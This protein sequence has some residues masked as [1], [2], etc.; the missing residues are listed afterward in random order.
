MQNRLLL[1]ALSFLPLVSQAAHLHVLSSND[2]QITFELNIDDW[3]VRPLSHDRDSLAVFAFDGA[4]YL[5]EPGAPRLPVKTVVIGIPPAGDATMNVAE[6]S[7]DVVEGVLPAPTP[8]LERS[9]YGVR[10]VHE[11]DAQAYRETAEGLE[12]VVAEAPFWFRNQ[13]VLRLR[14]TPLSFSPAERRVKIYRR[15]MVNVTFSES[16]PRL[17]AAPE[18]D[19][20]VYRSLLLNYEQAKGMR[21]RSEPVA[22]LRKTG[23]SMEGDNWFK[24]VISAR[25]APDREGIYKLTGAALKQAL[26]SAFA[27]A[28]IDPATL[29][30]FNNGGRELSTNVIA[31]KNDT[32]IE[33]PVVVVGGED[34]RFDE[35]DYLLFYGRSVEGI[36]FKTG[37]KRL[38]H[39]IN[40]YTY[41]NVYWLTFNRRTGKRVRAVA[42]AEIADLEPQPSFRDLVWSEEERINIFKSGTTWLGRELTRSN[43]SY[44]ITFRMPDAVPQDEAEFRF[45][46]A[47]LTSGTHYFT[48][49][50][51]GNSIGQ[52]SQ[53]GSAYSF[54][55]SEVT[56]RSA[57]VLLSGDNIVTVNYGG[58]TDAAFSYVDYIEA[59]YNRRFKA[60][61]DQ[62][63]FFSPLAS[64]RL[65]YRI[66]GFSRDDVRIFDVTDVGDVREILPAAVAGGQVDFA[67]FGNPVF[68]KR[69][70]AVS[71]AGFK[72]VDPSWISR[73]S[74]AGLRNRSVKADY[75]IITHDSFYQQALQLESL[76]EN[77]SPKERLETEVVAVSDVINEFGWGLPDPSATRNFLAWA[78][79]HWGHPRYVLMLGDGHFDFKNLLRQNAPN[80]IIP[81][82]TEGT[83]E[84]NTRTTDDWFTYTRGDNAGMQ[85]AIGRLPVQTV[86][87]AQALV[88]KIVQYETRPEFG[89]W[90]K[91]VTIVADDEYTDR[92]DGERI[93]TEQAERLAEN[94]V[95]E[96]LNV[97]KIYLINYP[98]VKTASISGREK[99]KATAELLEQINRGSLI[100][101]YIGHGND[102]LW[103]HERVLMRSRDLEKIQNG[104]RAAMWVAATCEFAYWDQPKQQ[105]FAEDILNAAGRGAVAMVSSA[106]LA[107]SDQNAAFNYQLY[108]QLFSG[109]ASTGLT[110]RIGDAVMLGKLTQWDRRNAEKY[111]LFGDP[112]M[113]LCAPRLR[114]VIESVTPDSIQA[115]SLMTVTGRVE[116]GGSPIDYNGRLLVRVMDTRKRYTYRGESGVQ[117][118]DLT[119]EGA[120][121]FRGMVKITDGR[122]KVQFIVP[123]DISYGGNDG[124]ISLYFW[125]EE[126][127]GTGIRSRLPVGGTST[128]LVDAEG[129]RMTLDFGNERFVSGDYVPIRP[130]LRL[131]IS[132][133]LSGVNTAGDIGHQITLTLDNDFAA[134]RDITEYFTYNEG[135]YTDG[136]LLYTLYD[137]TPGEHTLMIKAWDN[138]NNSSIIEADFVAVEESKLD[139]RNLL[140]YPNP[141]R[142]ECTF[143][144]EL[145]QDAEV[146]LRIYTVAGRLIKKTPSYPARAGYNIFPES[147]DGCDQDGDAVA[148]GVYLYKLTAK[149]SHAGRTLTTEKLEK[150]VIA[151]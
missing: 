128:A 115:L 31:A 81:Y 11:T 111:A 66:S 12:L 89:E 17:T 150:L 127:S 145:S 45:S 9:E 141:M 42:S 116:N 69:Y 74:L 113:R 136:T 138:S 49:Y 133:S 73:A 62:L 56:F 109:Y 43:S 99:P 110:A 139:I 3:S 98:A 137:L 108:Q 132:D 118:S 53:Y 6:A 76:R 13:R 14:L 80:L 125:N 83:S 26:G 50:A 93:H 121:L 77:W 24:I 106:R 71:P 22:P 32:L 16:S 119:A 130:T 126:N 39:Y 10:E 48:F 51:N 148:D 47:S 102:E 105:S 143:R 65:R 7:F 40:P 94:Y 29:Q 78:Q 8:R 107:F 88:D 149:A 103:A 95:P 112:A 146:S 35:A 25:S 100:I 70:A 104:R 117:I 87:E 82:E 135:S 91:T 120:T 23:T 67:D 142:N 33:T 46:L 63:L 1:I 122:F 58:A 30:L 131:T 5:G 90:L 55:L 134:S 75:I 64:G 52:F 151:R 144:F 38:A 37:K 92:D 123:K 60:T 57:G 72:N 129:P 2:R 44:S 4:D 41:A 20:E 34:G 61:G 15:L 101:N 97:K 59:E 84:N 18:A 28:E 54:P 27:L 114:A 85:M 21:R 96:L 124:R 140:T 19:E 68:S 36:E 147:W 79:D 86:E